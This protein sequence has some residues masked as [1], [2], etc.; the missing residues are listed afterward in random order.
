M[1]SGFQRKGS[2]PG[3]RISRRIGRAIGEYGL[4]EEGDRVLVAL[5]GGKDSY[6][7]LH[8]LAA[9]RRFAPVHYEL[10]A[11]HVRFEHLCGAGAQRDVLEDRCARLGVP[12]HV[13]PATVEVPEGQPLNCHRCATA[14]RNALFR[15][16]RT[17]GSNKLALGHHLDDI[18]ETVLLNLFFRG[19]FSTMVP[20]LPLFDGE[21]TL[22][23][24][25]AFAE[26]ADILRFVDEETD[27][28]RQ[29][30]ECPVGR[31]TQRAKM[32]TLVKNLEQDYPHVRQSVFRAM[33]NIKHD[34]L[35]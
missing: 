4:L 2:T 30:C 33:R 9:R 31:D 23:R 7:A 16:A 6:T 24:P 3:A 32:K 29:T 28:P 15:L 34:Y 8:M 19:E 20:S 26:E 18:V 10:T 25:L 35:A 13:V 17:L 27:V 5:S 14:R 22:I 11:A 12:L 1:A 21:L